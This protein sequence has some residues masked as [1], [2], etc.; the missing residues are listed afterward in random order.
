VWCEALTA[1]PFTRY[2]SRIFELPADTSINLPALF[3]AAV[4]AKHHPRPQ[5]LAC[6]KRFASRAEAD[7]ARERRLQ[8][9]G[10]VIKMPIVA[11][12]WQYEPTS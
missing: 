9:T 4:V 10:A 6:D 2:V 1:P 3:G 8:G 12:E 7:A 5:E 11:V